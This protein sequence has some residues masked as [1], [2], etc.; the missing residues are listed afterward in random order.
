MNKVVINTGQPRNVLGHIISGAV[1]SAIVSGT[2]NYKKVKEQK[3]DSKKA[4]A[5]TVKIS[6]Q[7]AIATGTAVATANYIGQKGGLLKALT[8]VSIGMAGIYAIEFIDEKLKNQNIEIEDEYK[9]LIEEEK[10]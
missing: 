8:A 9:N 10:R 7:G 5:D 4:I 2:I 3:I 1:A 6:S